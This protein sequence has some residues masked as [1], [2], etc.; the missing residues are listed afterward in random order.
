MNPSHARRIALLIAASNYI[1]INTKTFDMKLALSVMILAFIYPTTI[2][3]QVTIYP[4]PA[5][6]APSPDYQVTINGREAFVYASPVPAA[7]CS[8]ELDTPVIVTIKANR[9]VKWVDV[10]PLSAGIKASFRD[11]TITIQL[12][13]P[14][15]LSIELNGSRHMPLFLFANAPEHNR[16]LKDDKNTR[17]FAAGKVYHPGI[18]DL[19]SNQTLYIE[20][21]A[22]V[23][24]VVKA[25][26]AK[27]IRI[28][29]RGIL[30]GS[31]NNNFPVGDGAAY[32]RFLE[33]RDCEDVRVEDLTLHNSTSWQVVPIHCD[34][35]HIEGLKIISNYN[36]DDGMDIVRSRNVTISGCFIRT[37]DDCIAIKSLFDYPPSEGVDHVQV[38]KSVFWNG[39]WGNGLEIGFELNSAEVRDVVFRDNDII[40]I[41]DGAAISIH[42]AGRATVHH[43]L[44]DNIR[45][46]DANQ[47][48]FDLAIFRSR[49][50]EDSS[51][52]AKE[53]KALYLN[54]AWDGVLAVPQAEKA[55]HAAFR[56]RIEDV[57][58]RDIHI[59]DGL[60]PYSVFYGYDSTH[61]VKDVTIQDLVVHGHTISNLEDAHLRMEN[62]RNIGLLI[63]VTVHGAKHTTIVSADHAPG[64]NTPGN[65]QNQAAAA[66]TAIDPAAEFPQTSS[67]QPDDEGF[68]PIF[69]GKTLNGWIGDSTYWRVEDGCLVGVVTPKTLLKRNSFIIWQGQM[70]ENFEIKVEFKVSDHGNSGINYRSELIEGQPWAM[71]GYQADL[72]GTREYTGSNYE[73]RRRT[74]LASRGQKVYTISMPSGDSLQTHIENNFWMLKF[75]TESLGDPDQLTAV[76]RV[77]DWNEY[78]IIVKGNRMQHYVN[79]ILMSEVTDNDDIN[80]RLTGLL[81]VQVH[82][83]PPMRIAY[84][85]FRLKSLD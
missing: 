76:I 60:F 10:R 16:P 13:K 36:S 51:K 38:E 56:G 12:V 30:D 52:D 53:N 44:Y 1:S 72:N 54:G 58:F 32:H 27:H 75:G 28:C 68:V 45:I 29:G 37:K 15:E 55:A 66:S 18:I 71:R 48:L 25:D 64:T 59:V 70:P 31:Q 63:T 39:V 80:R 69:D 22:V 5:G 26:H 14:V 79:G 19:K 65:Q 81:G 74:T 35:V 57:V 2:D 77:D 24:G 62:A 84:R 82:V 6:L 17:W 78:H 40:H 42:N 41:E 20:A 7:Y 9:D 8:F 34:Q 49:Y 33:F 67:P 21:G 11:S 73:E 47:K 83:G 4:S 50:S 61:A 85:N 46:E 3:A 43:I 23:V